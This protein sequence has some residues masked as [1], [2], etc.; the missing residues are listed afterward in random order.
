MGGLTRDVKPRM[1]GMP[2]II[3]C[4]LDPVPSEGGTTGA[5]MVGCAL[6]HAAESNVR[7]RQGAAYIATQ[8][9]G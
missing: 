9:S 6:A 2:G 3:H 4:K 1:T 7:V 5:E 8:F